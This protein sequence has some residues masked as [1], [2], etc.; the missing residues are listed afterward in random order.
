MLR[1][2]DG[3]LVYPFGGA[4]TRTRASDAVCRIRKTARS[5]AD[6][7]FLACLSW[8][9]SAY[10]RGTDRGHFGGRFACVALRGEQA[11]GGD[12]RASRHRHQGNA[13]GIHHHSHAVYHGEER[14]A[15]GGGASYGH[16]H[17]IRQRQKGYHVRPRRSFRGRGDV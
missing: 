3:G 2:L 13:R 17:C 9:C 14:C 8:V 16:S 7:G 6:G 11:H 1:V 10:L 12:L 5:F 15:D 4:R